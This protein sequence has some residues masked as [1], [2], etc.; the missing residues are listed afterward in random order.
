KI[1][2]IICS[3]YLLWAMSY[4]LWLRLGG[5]LPV[6]DIKIELLEPFTKGFVLGTDIYG[7][8][9]LGMLSAGV[10]Y[11]LI[12]AI[13]TA[14]TSAIIGVI[15]G[16]IMALASSKFSTILEAICNTIYIF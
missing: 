13:V 12:F 4:F 8:S 7:R 6:Q 15:A 10:M 9:L 16:G 1:G 11:S 5:E 14:L 2:L 3:L